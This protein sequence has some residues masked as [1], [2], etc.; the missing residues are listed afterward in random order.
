MKVTG[1]KGEVVARIFVAVENNVPTLQTAEEV[2]KEIASQNTMK[3]RNIFPT[4]SELKKYQILSKSQKA[5]FRKVKVKVKVKVKLWPQT[6]HPD[7]FNFLAFNPNELASKDLS[8]YETS[9]GYS[10]YQDGFLKPLDFNEI[11]TKSP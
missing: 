9:K 6:W 5:G 1:R 7:N 2:G 4:K 11:S 10:C 8:D 3:L